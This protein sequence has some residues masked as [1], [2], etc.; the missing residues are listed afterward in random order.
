MRVPEHPSKNQEIAHSICCYP[1]FP[2]NPFSVLREAVP[3]VW[4][5]TATACFPSLTRRT[6]RWSAC[7]N[8]YHH[9]I[10]P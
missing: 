3:K 7:F 5:Q 9:N 4:D 1:T 10:L 2:L 8:I 6:P